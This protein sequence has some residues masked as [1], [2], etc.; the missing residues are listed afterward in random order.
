VSSPPAVAAAAAAG[1]VA[2]SAVSQPSDRRGGRA[3][4]SALD[5]ADVLASDDVSERRVPPGVEV[6]LVCAG[7]VTS[8][9]LRRSWLSGVFVAV[10]VTSDSCVREGERYGIP[11]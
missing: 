11:N 1:R 7:N 2:V 4:A 5:R 3:A 9:S 10:V 6:K 8:G